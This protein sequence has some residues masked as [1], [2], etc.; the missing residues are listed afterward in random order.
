MHDRHGS[1]NSFTYFQRA[2]RLRCS[3]LLIQ[4]GTEVDA[5]GSL[6]TEWSQSSGIF[7]EDLG[8][9][10]APL[11]SI[12]SECE[13][14]KQSF[15]ENPSIS[16]KERTE[17]YLRLHTLGI[18]DYVDLAPASSWIANKTNP[19]LTIKIEPPSCK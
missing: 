6:V 17:R 13:K 12:D 5:Q 19:K 18:N 9:V 7:R 8:T 15:L 4:R 16:K 3:C 2:C 11:D 10:E 14:T 1:I